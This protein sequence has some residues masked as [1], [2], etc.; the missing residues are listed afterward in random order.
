MEDKVNK[1]ELVKK[2]AKI[3]K[4]VVT[5]L[6]KYPMEIYVLKNA[7]RDLSELINSKEYQNIQDG[8]FLMF[9]Y[10]NFI[11][12][13]WAHVAAHASL[14]ITDS[15]IEQIIK[16]IVNGLGKLANSL[17]AYDKKGIYDSLKYLIFNY[18]VELNKE[19]EYDKK[20]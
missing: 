15:Q 16:K 20:S 8:K 14:K 2:I 13:L 11:H 4:K 19:V 10:E 12:H 9:F 18:L 7:E 6:E 17:E 1:L 5:H 3:F